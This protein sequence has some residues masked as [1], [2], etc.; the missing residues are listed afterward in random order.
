MRQLQRCLDRTAVVVTCQDDGLN[1]YTGVCVYSM[2]VGGDSKCQS[3]KKGEC[4]QDSLRCVRP[5]WL[6]PLWL[7][8]AQTAKAPNR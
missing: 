5:L 1:L 2:Y 3:D 8:A 7:G 4:M 6:Q